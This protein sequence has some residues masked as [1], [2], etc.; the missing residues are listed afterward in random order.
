MKLDPELSEQIEVA[1]R[2]GQAV[3]AA[4]Y[5]PADAAQNANLAQGVIDR[6][7]RVAN[8]VPGFVNVLKHLGVVIVSASPAYIRRMIEQPEFESAMANRHG[9]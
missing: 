5:M 6:V 8:E 3:E 7:T 9:P 2:T 1:E 4:F